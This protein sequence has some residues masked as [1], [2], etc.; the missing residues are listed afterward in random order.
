M[1]YFVSMLKLLVLFSI[2]QPPGYKVEGLIKGAEGKRIHLIDR[3][4]YNKTHPKFTVTTDTAG[5]FTFKG[6]ID[7]PTYYGLMVEGINAQVEF[8]LQNAKIN[9]TGDADSLWTAHVTGSN[10]TDIKNEFASFTGYEAN[11]SLYNTYETEHDAA[12]KAGDTNASSLWQFRRDSLMKGMRNAAGRFINK[13]PHSITA[14]NSIVYY[15]E[16]VNEA[17]SLVRVFE[18][19][20]I[21]DNKQVLYFRK[22]IDK[23]K[24]I[25]VGSMAPAFTLKDTGNTSVSLSSFKGKYVLLDFWASWCGPCRQESANL[26][27]IYRKNS[28]KGFTI[29]SVSLD[30]S[31]DSWMKA[32]RKDKLG[33]WTHLSDLKGWNNK[34]ANIYGIDQIPTSLLIGK[35]GRI[36]A[37]N[38]RGAA[39]EQMVS[40]LSAD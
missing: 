15:M 32:I 38:L 16:D 20:A 39:L 14:I 36:I 18:H 33:A 13:Y 23:K 9:I 35:D 31:K 27:N 8:I 12:V 25:T 17:D 40:S 30:E 10:E 3:A 5:R 11:Q 24:S 2:F 6:I 4:F 22:L 28:T 1:L 7:E 34:V 37:K 26:V 29:V 21:G 19:S